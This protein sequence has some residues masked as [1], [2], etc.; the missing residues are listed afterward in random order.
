MAKILIVEDE[1][2]VQELL[3]L[4][5]EG[6][7]YMTVTADNGKTAGNWVKEVR[8]DLA[9]LDLNLPDMNGMQICMSIKEDPKTRATPVIILT[10]N[11]SN[12]AR[13]KSN[14]EAKADLFLNK[15]INTDDLKGAVKMMLETA[16]KRKL[17][18]RNSIRTRL[19]E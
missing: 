6:D 2:S 8:F 4:C 1:P 10:G 16:E 9:I 5:L 17:L 19:G 12:E 18:L 3:K 11:N 13:I 15:P 7:G 14:F